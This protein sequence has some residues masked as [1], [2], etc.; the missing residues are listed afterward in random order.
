MAHEQ[1]LCLLPHHRAWPARRSG[2]RPRR[3]ARARPLDRDRPCAACL[4]HAILHRRGSADRQ[5]KNRNK[6]SPADGGAGYRLRDCGAGARRHLFRRRRGGRQH[7]RPHQKSRP[8]RDVDAARAR[9]GRSGPKCAPA[10]DARPR[11]RQRGPRMRAR[12]QIDPTAE[13]VPLPEAASRRRRAPAPPQKAD[14]ASEDLAR[15]ISRR[16]YP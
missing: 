1:I 15:A 10:P 8:V 6:I 13:E 16:R 7:G 14:A 5:R 9:S 11:P 2:R 4:R 3:A 12:Q